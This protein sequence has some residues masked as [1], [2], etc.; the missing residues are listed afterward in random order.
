MKIKTPL[1]QYCFQPFLIKIRDRKE[2]RFLEIGP[3][4]RR[5]QNFETVNIIKS[6][7]TD[8]VSDTTKK[9]PFSDNTFNIVYASHVLEHTPWYLSEKT[10][11]EWARV[12]KPGGKVEIW[13]PDS[14]KIAKAFV[15]GVERNNKD[16]L[17]DGWFRFNEEK[18][19]NKWFS[20]RMFSYGDGLG[21]R[22]HFNYHLSAYSEEYLKEL[23]K[24][25]GFIEVKKMRHA[26]CRGD[27]HGWINLGITGIKK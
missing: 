25:S 2:K 17:K 26:E 18:N 21:T 15:E 3:G 1:Y 16:F 27:D 5:I 4:E 20:G 9:L 6:K 24:N 10:V 14:Y 12:L 8:Y 13:V 19:I 22:G 11:K 7:S 23:L